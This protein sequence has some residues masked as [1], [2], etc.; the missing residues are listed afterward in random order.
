MK[1]SI[2]CFNSFEILYL[3]RFGCTL[4]PRQALANII[5][6]TD[7]KLKTPHNQ[8]EFHISIEEHI[9]SKKWDPLY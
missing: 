3:N 1:S 6:V 5:P 7:K 8:Y 4:Q 2:A 9:P